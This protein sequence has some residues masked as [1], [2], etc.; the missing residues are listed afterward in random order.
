MSIVNLLQAMFEFFIHGG[1]SHL[2][3]CYIDTK[4]YIRKEQIWREDLANLV[5][6]QDA[7]SP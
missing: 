4:D 2:S 1:D 5:A 7:K 3:Q 6:G